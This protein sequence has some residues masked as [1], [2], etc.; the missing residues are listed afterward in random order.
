MKTD[1]FD[2]LVIEYIKENKTV[3]S[4]AISN[5][6]VKFLQD[7]GQSMSEIIE[8]MLQT[9]DEEYQNRIENK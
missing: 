7:Y 5:Q 4:I 1:L 2:K 3:A 8:N 6:D 9:V